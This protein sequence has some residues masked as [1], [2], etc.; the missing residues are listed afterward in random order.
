M[1]LLFVSNLQRQRDREREGDREVNFIDRM[2]MNNTSMQLWYRVLRMSLPQAR[3]PGYVVVCT[4]N[5]PSSALLCDGGV[6]R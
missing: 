3:N 4:V 5:V 6:L 2:F 1:G